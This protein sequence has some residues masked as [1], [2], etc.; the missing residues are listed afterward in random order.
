MIEDESGGK[1]LLA[2]TVFSLSIRYLKED[3][4]KLSES[5]ITG[6]GLRDEDIHWVLTVPAIWNDAAKQFMREAADEVSRICFYLYENYK[7]S[8]P[9]IIFCFHVSFISFMTI[10]DF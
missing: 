5:R 6:G 9:T 8:L 7:S 1:K 2:K 4:I 10:T 3:L